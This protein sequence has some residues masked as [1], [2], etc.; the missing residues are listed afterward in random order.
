MPSNSKVE[1]VR[2][3]T[4]VM[5][6]G[7]EHQNLIE[8]RLRTCFETFGYRPIGVPIVEY[9]ELHL[10][11]S[12]ADIV[13]RLYDFVYQSRRL[14]L[15]PEMTASVV[16]AY[17]DNLQSVPLPIRLSYVGPV[18]RYEKPQKARYR[19]F[20]EMGVELLG[21]TQPVADAEVIHLACKGLDLLGLSH[22]RLVLGHIGILTKFLDSLDLESRLRNFLLANMET[23]R[24]EGEPFVLAQLH[25]AYPTLK[26]ENLRRETPS[27]PPRA[28]KLAQ[29]LEEMPPPDSRAVIA[30]LLAGMHIDLDSSRDPEEMIDRLLV[31]LKRQD[32]LPQLRRALDF[33]DELGQLVGDPA[34]VMAEAAK[35]IP[36]YR[37]DSTPLDELQAILET[38]RMYEMADG[39]LSLDLGLTRGLQYYTGTIF[40]IYDGQGSE[41]MQLCG[42]GR[43][44]DLAT[45][46][47][48]QQD[49]PA[50]GFSYGLE[51]LMFAGERAG[52]QRA[53]H[54]HALDALV[55]PV[56]LNEYGYAA[57][58]AEQLR[59]AGLRVEIDVRDRSV[60]S[61]LQYADKRHI[62]FVLIVGAEEKAQ[63]L[64]TLR[65]MVS[66]TESSLSLGNAAAK[67]KTEGGQHE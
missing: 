37:L 25:R 9:T 63:S 36:A 12:G 16:R 1:R 26:I 57:V 55:I 23:R 50:V 39:R 15:R 8:R 20:T 31:R 66:R 27:P 61:N 33:M 14:C 22:Y 42:G 54:R 4:D 59:E 65:N 67:I 60:K 32:Q 10:R 35:L 29:L 44:D 7:C 46:L 5:P 30:E 6:A 51:R 58:V 53:Q 38:L 56:S 19:Q 49:V 21:G 64:V 40:E 41:A 2:G 48:S 52:L 47:G 43:Y 3:M 11:K 28:E 34:H 13:S 24:K 17:V 18:F 62:P 45:T